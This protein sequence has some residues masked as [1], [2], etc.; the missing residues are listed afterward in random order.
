MTTEQIDSTFADVMLETAIT[1]CA[2]KFFTGNR[3]W[4]LQALRQ[5]RPDVCGELTDSLGKQIAAYLGDMDKN[6]K[7]IFC[8]Q[9]DDDHPH[10]NNFKP[11]SVGWKGSINLVAWVDRKSAALAALVAA[12]ENALLESQKKHIWKSPSNP[13][14]VLLEVKMVGD[15]D[16]DEQRGAGV[17]AR[18]EVIRSTR[19]WPIA[20]RIDT[21]IWSSADA[22]VQA[23]LLATLASF[24]PEL[25]PEN[26]IVEHA[27]AIEKIPPDQRGPLEYHLTELKVALIRKIISD[28]L[29][30]INIAKEWFTVSDLDDLLQRRIGPGKIG[31]KAAGMILAARILR[32]VADEDVQDCLRVPESYFIG[33]DSIY[34]FT[35]MNGLMHWNDQKYKPEDQIRSEYAQIQT[36]FEAGRFPPEILAKLRSILEE[37]GPQPLIVRSSSQLEDNF[38]TSFA[39]KYESFF[40]PNQGS[41]EENLDALTH[42]IKCT[43]ASTLKP[44]A[45]LYRKQKGL[46]DYDE[47][48]AILIQLVQGEK[49]GRYFLPHAAGVAFSHNLFRWSPQI[50]REAGIARMVWGLG[51]RAVG[52]VGDDYPRLIALSHPMLQPDDS[53]EAIRHYSQHYVDVIDLEANAL[54]TLPVEDV[55][56]P[57]YPALRYIAQIE[58]DGYFST[59]RMRVRQEDIP[60][61]GITFNELLRRTAFAETL[62][63]IL[64]ALERHYHAAV[65]VEFTLRVLDPNAPQPQVQISLLQC[66]PQSRLQDTCPVEIPEGLSDEE[67]VLSTSYM[68]PQGYL[69]EIR[70]VLYVPH[71]NYYALP[72]AADR[73]KLGFAISRLNAVLDKRAYI[74][75]GPGRWGSTNTDLGVYVSY[76]DVYNAGSLV[77]LSGEGI[78]PDPE[79]SLGTHFFQDLMEAQIYPLVVRIDDQNSKFNH[80]FFYNTPNSVSDWIDLPAPIEACLHLVD[81]AKFRPGHHLELIMDDGK[82]QAVAFLAPDRAE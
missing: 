17:F 19:I 16:V 56:T 37:I 82:G 50:Q 81:V 28:Q 57:R 49:F 66:R 58:Q 32:E 44:D 53:A 4:A 69:P 46:Q 6:V 25:A 30:Y 61:L 29:S 14:R 24:D 3:Q 20:D 76:A 41:L 34:I 39:G 78:G 60:R 63:K 45:L 62:S 68:I 33:S 15:E 40:C 9:A 1:A 11:S 36:E 54:E 18:S 7:A 74:C 12:L 48:M 80:A 55:L 64:R 35:A 42:A 31:G 38:G 65:D 27:Y 75:V 47:R 52:R 71:E 67:I 72:T 10:D 22:T 51:T 26:K 43:Y 59:P 21:D 2:E 77:E 13:S 23:S 73:D 8:Y 5:G 70:Y 79:P